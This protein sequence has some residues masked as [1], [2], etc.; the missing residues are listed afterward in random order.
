MSNSL[1]FT[2]KATLTN[3][4]TS[5]IIKE[6][7]N[8][9][10]QLEFLCQ[11]LEAVPNAVAILNRERQ[12][13]YANPAFHGYINGGNPVE[14]IGARVG[15][16]VGC[17][18]AFEQTTGCGTSETCTTCGALHAMLQAQQGK[19]S[20]QECRITRLVKDEMEA[21]DLRVWATPFQIEQDVFT[22][23]AA[24]DIAN[25]KRRNILERIFFH[26]IRNTAGVIY[27]VAELMRMGVQ[28]HEGTEFSQLLIQASQKLLDEINAQQQ[29]LA[30]EQG[31]LIVTQC[32]ILSLNVLHRVVSLYEKHPVATERYLQIAP[33]A[34]SFVIQSDEALLGRVIANMV[35]NALEACRPGETVTLGCKVQEDQAY[36]WV[37]NP[38]F[39]P[40]NVQLQ[41]FNRSFSTKG[42]DRGLGTYSI[43]LLT[44]QYLHGS[45]SFTSSKE[46][47]TVFTAVYPV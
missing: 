31:E 23:F 10:T 38:S 33:D 6:Q 18:H 34:E 5:E 17:I 41:V 42:K 24:T 29:I 16:A 21:V 25:E 44:E 27:G 40:R 2:P 20:V 36:F 39:M 12:I 1:I 46:E 11:A 14:I 37:H 3:R 35:K 30:A 4:L 26:D 22:I 43:K 7:E 9:F 19:K 15:E 45:V 47:G 32:P 28:E 8:T 13:I